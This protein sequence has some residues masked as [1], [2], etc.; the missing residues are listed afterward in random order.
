MK[1]E[2]VLNKA[3][4]GEAGKATEQKCAIPLLEKCF[5]LIFCYSS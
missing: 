1:V 2:F 4:S 5:A 3:A